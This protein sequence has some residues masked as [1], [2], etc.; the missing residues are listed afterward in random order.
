[1]EFGRALETHTGLISEVVSQLF[2]PRN[3][4]V[5]FYGVPDYRGFIEQKAS[6]CRDIVAA[7][8]LRDTIKRTRCTSR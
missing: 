8:M 7:V 6:I 3:T 4:L 5:P 2:R 1:M